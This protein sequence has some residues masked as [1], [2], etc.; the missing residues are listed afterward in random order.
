MRPAQNAEV[1][2]AH[3]DAREFAPARE[4]LTAENQVKKRIVLSINDLEIQQKL[5][6]YAYEFSQ[7][8]GGQLEVLQILTPSMMNSIFDCVHHPRVETMRQMG[9]AYKIIVGAGTP[10]EDILVYARKKR[11]IHS[12]LLKNKS[13]DNKMIN[14]VQIMEQLDVPVVVFSEIT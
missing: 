7:R 9:I 8:V 11:N 13:Y 5:L 6:N 4:I 12:L 10:E 1:T 3:V 14:F 2:S